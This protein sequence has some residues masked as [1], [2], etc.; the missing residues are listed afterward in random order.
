MPDTGNVPVTRNCTLFYAPL[1][2]NDYLRFCESVA[3]DQRFDEQKKKEHQPY[4]LSYV[5][6]IYSNNKLYRVF[7]LKKE[8]MSVMKPV[9]DMCSEKLRLGNSP[10]LEDIKLHCFSSGCAFVEFYVSYDGLTLEEIENF[11]YLFKKATKVDE[12]NGYNVS[13]CDVIEDLFIKDKK[14]DFNFAGENFK[15]ECRMFHH[16]FVD[17][18]ADKE[19]TVSHLRRLARGYNTGFAL[20]NTYG[21]YDMVYTPYD[22]DCWAGSQEGMVNLF[23]HSGNKS[24]DFFVDNLKRSHLVG[25]YGFMYLLLLNQRFTAVRLISEITTYSEYSR[26]QK[27]ALNQRIVDLKTIFAFNIV[28]DDQLYQNVYKRMYDLMDIDR[29]LDDIK[30]NEQQ[31]EMIR[32]YESLE[33]EKKTSSFLFG[34]SILSVFSVLI[35]AASYFDR[36]PLL[37]EISTV[38]SF[39]CMSAIITMYL[40]WWIRYLKK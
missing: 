17:E 4:F 23:S 15:C 30:D 27:A 9:I 7:E 6:R 11:S 33:T 35:D 32:N 8:H 20:Q 34:L 40:I 39:G 13:M 29:L 12:E 19:S 31:V 2:T 21:D 14:A 25:Y 1:W 18:M 22:Y 24:A 36:I 5:T 16:I 10:R 37:R 3:N 26:K 28:S 38:L